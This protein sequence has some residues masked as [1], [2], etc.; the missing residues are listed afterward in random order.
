MKN[1]MWVAGLVLIVSLVIW[2]KSGAINPAL[3]CLYSDNQNKIETICV[4]GIK[5]NSLI[6]SP[7]TVTGR[8]RGNWFFEASFPLELLSQ[9]NQVLAQN[10]AQAEGDWMTTDL[11]PFIAELQFETPLEGDNGKL[12]FK[13]DNSSGLPE[14]D[15]QLIIPVRFR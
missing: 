10:H 2:F 3:T 7:L 13:N 4:D 5:N 8:A 1:W 9:D 14:N 12:I 6:K 15:A 11:V